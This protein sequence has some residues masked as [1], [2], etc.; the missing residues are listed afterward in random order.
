MSTL[1][2]ETQQ[3]PSLQSYIATLDA[4]PAPV[5]DLLSTY[6]HIPA[7]EQKAHIVEFRERA[8]KSYP[9]PCL[10]RWRF[11]ELDLSNHPLYHSDILPALGP[12]KDGADDWIFLDLGTCLGQ[13]VRKLIFDGADPARVYGA[14]LKPEFIE[15]GYALFRDQDKFPRDHF[16]APANVFDFSADNELSRKCDGRVGILHS[17]AVFHLFALPEQKVMARRCL[18]LLDPRRKRVLI[19]G[20]QVGNENPSEFPRQSGGMRFRH[21][22]DSWRDM[23]KEVVEED[24]WKGK[25]RGVEVD[26]TM[27][28]RNIQD[29]LGERKTVQGRGMWEPGMRWMKWWVWVDFV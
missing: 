24:D 4:V 12:A 19:C 21:N 26:G 14:D 6:S 2:G 27:H 3:L 5:S 9:Y 18:R 7:G 16:I 25:I 11:L 1:P 23:W 22:I 8:Y 28:G 10:G 13:D 29:Q 15:I 20:A 17:C